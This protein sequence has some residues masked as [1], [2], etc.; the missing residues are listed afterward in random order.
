MLTYVSTHL[1]TYSHGKVTRA[2]PGVFKLLDS[3]V[4]LAAVR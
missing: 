1:P 4:T 2:G 3:Q